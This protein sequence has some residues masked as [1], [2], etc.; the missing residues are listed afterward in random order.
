MDYSALSKAWEDYKKLIEFETFKDP[1]V[2]AAIEHA[3]LAG[4]RAASEGVEK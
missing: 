1:G 3:F 2:L 4:F